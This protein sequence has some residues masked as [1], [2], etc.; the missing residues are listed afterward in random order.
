[1]VAVFG[2]DHVYRMDPR[3]M[4]AAHRAWGAGVTVAGAPVPRLSLLRPW[5]GGF[6]VARTGPDGHRIVSFREKAADPAWPPR[7]SSGRS[8]RVHGQ[9]PVRPGFPG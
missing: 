6:G 1:M 5:V 2:A 3:Q 7:R 8:L 4:L 9:L